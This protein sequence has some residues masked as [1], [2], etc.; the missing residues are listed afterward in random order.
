MFSRALPGYVIYEHGLQTLINFITAI[1]FM[2]IQYA[3]RAQRVRL[4]T[5]LFELVIL[6]L[7]AT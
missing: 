3:E 5:L 1:S 4:T 7:A 6:R 2:I